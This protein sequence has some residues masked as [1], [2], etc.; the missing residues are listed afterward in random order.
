MKV[1]WLISAISLFWSAGCMHG[2]SLPGQAWSKHGSVETQ[3]FDSDKLGQLNEFLDQ[4]ENTTGLLVIHDGK[5]LYEYG[6]LDRVSYIASCRKSVL[7][8]LF[9]KYVENGTIDLNETIGNIGIDEDDGLLPIEKQATIGHIMTSR[10]GVFHKASNGGY[11]L[12]NFRPRGSETPGEYFVYNNWDFNVAGHIL[13]HYA[14]RSLYEEIEEQLAIPLGF[15]DWNI[16]NQ[17]KYHNSDE[18]QYPAYHMFISTRDMAKIGQLMLNEG[19]WNGRQI[20][21]KSWI[22]KI[23]TPVTPKEVVAKRYKDRSEGQPSMAYSY[24]WWNFDRFHDDARYEGSYT[25]AGY[26]GQFITVIPRMNLVIAHKSALG[27]WEYIGLA[28][29]GVT[30]ANYYK[31]MDKV[32]QAYRPSSAPV[33][34]M[35]KTTS[36]S[37]A[38]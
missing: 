27:F 16:K 25:A 9:G 23:T 38:P 35:P 34:A 10:S 21:S 20:V 24:M 11:D 17:K 14:K 1:R 13:E 18:S 37:S 12:D 36:H 28:S 29:W 32:V 15:E 22:R 4:Q 3:G 26:G 31:I 19:V 30:A 5:V 8:I 33:P 2:G 6:D 7:S